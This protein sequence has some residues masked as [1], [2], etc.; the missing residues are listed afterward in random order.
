M[1]LIVNQKTEHE[2]KLQICKTVAKLRLIT[3]K[4]SEWKFIRKRENL[5]SRNC[6]FKFLLFLLLANSRLKFKKKSFVL[7]YKSSRLRRL[8]SFCKNKL[9]LTALLVQLLLV[10]FTRKKLLIEVILILLFI[11]IHF[12]V[13]AESM[14]AETKNDKR[15]LF[16][17]ATGTI[18]CIK[19]SFKTNSMEVFKTK[20]RRKKDLTQKISFSK[21]F[22]SIFDVS[23]NKRNT[24]NINRNESRTNTNYDVNNHSNASGITNTK[25]DL[26]ANVERTTSKSTELIIKNKTNLSLNVNLSQAQALDASLE[27]N[28]STTNPHSITN[29]SLAQNNFNLNSNLNEAPITTSLAPLK[30]A[31]ETLADYDFSTPLNR[32]TFS[33][34]DNYFANISR[35]I[36]TKNSYSRLAS[37]SIKHATLTKKNNNFNTSLTEASKIKFSAAFKNETTATTLANYKLSTVQNKQLLMENDNLVSTN[38]E[39]I[40]N[41]NSHSSLGAYNTRNESLTKKYDNLNTN[42]TEFS[43]TTTSAALKNATTS[44]TLANHKISTLPYRQ[45]FSQ[46][47][48]LATNNTEKVVTENTHSNSATYII[49]DVSLTEKNDNLNVGSTNTSKTISSAAFKSVT[50]ATTLANYK[51][52]TVHNRQTFSQNDNFVLANTENSHS[53]LATHKITDASLTEKTNNLYIGLTETTS[54]AAF[55]DVTKA[56]IAANY[57][58]STIPYR[59]T[60]SQKDNLASAN[61][62]NPRSSLATHIITDAS[63]N[64]L[65]ISSTETSKTPPSAAFKNATTATIL[66][67]S[68]IYTVPNRQTFS[69]NDH[70]TSANTE[71]SHANLVTRIITD[72]S[73]TEKNDNRNISSKETLKTTFSAAFKNAT[74]LTTLANSKISTIPYKQTFSQNEYLASN[75]TEK[76]V[77][78]SSHSSLASHIPTYAILTEKTNK[79]YKSSTITSKTTSSAALK[80]A[81]K[82]TAPANYK[83]STVPYRQTFSQ[84]DNLASANTEK[85]VTEDIHSSLATHIITDVSNND[86]NIGSTDNSKTTSSAAFKKLTKVTTTENYKTFTV[87]NKQ[88]FWHINNSTSSNTENVFTNSSH[89]NSATHFITDASNNHLI[90]GSTE[91]SKTTYSA[92]FKNATTSTTLANS[93]ISTLPYRQTFSQNDNLASANTESF[94][95]SL[96]SRII[97]D[98]SLTEKSYNLNIISSE[99]LKTTSSAAFN[100]ETKA[101]TSASYRISTLPYRQKLSQNYGLASAKTKKAVTESSYSSL[102]SY[103]SANE[104]ITKISNNLNINSTKTSKI[105]SSESFETANT[106][107]TL[108]SYNFSTEPN[109]QTFSQNDNSAATF[110]AT[111][112]TKNSNSSSTSYSITN[113]L[114]TQK[115]NNFQISLTKTKVQPPI[116]SSSIFEI[117]TLRNYNM[118]TVRNREVFF[119]ILSI[120][121][122]T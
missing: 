106:I 58:I 109:R 68:K 36:D 14:S 70:L 117:A 103:N 116:T 7:N 28:I 81:T 53:N 101:K 8:S 77:T 35:K 25:T 43:K 20:L 18:K 108:P 73:L 47:D 112:K 42:S 63:N 19:S 66:A 49:T 5:L 60:F 34:N 15:C 61:T 33:Q 91:T 16:D 98:A 85:F 26:K 30:K 102:V 51:I 54:L 21:I 41:E 107:T 121:I 104:N 3:S 31:A 69:Q 75:N 13:Y 56:T 46:N 86:L 48:N 114:L 119:Y 84:N 9:L 93:K 17:D 27:L 120:K 55:K 118:S 89:S 52:S 82:V 11:I 92:A 12:S 59:Q 57:K 113:A 80:H 37:N 72:D 76:I 2:K 90:I 1:M 6:E 100:N 96:A 64:I 74:T 44:T 24:Q 79:L 62:V 40:I 38:A 67:N 94:H 83:F 110:T 115:T 65:S 22:F 87:P 99:T 4:T 105:T 88:V 10:S 50:T 111:T 78:E 39:R 97:T 45:T 122:K 32:N 29:D 23:G 71:Y 95:S